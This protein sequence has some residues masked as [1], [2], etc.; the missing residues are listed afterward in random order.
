[1]V[2]REEEELKQRQMAFASTCDRGGVG[3]WEK[4][5]KSSKE[6]HLHAIPF[7]RGRCW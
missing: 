7:G 1:M 2:V 4:E 5:V 6:K 3:P